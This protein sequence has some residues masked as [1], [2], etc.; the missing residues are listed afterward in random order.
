MML[1]YTEKIDLDDKY[2]DKISKVISWY[3]QKISYI[4]DNDLINISECEDFLIV[5]S[6]IL[7]MIPDNLKDKYINIGYKLAK[8]I[9][10]KIES[11]NFSSYYSIFFEGL[12]YSAYSIY[13]FNK[14]TGLLCNFLKDINLLLLN[15]SYKKASNLISSYNNDTTTFNYDVIYGLSGILNYLLDV[16]IKEEDSYKIETIIKYLVMVTEHVD[17]NDYTI[18][19][20]FIPNENLTDSEKEYFKFGNINLGLSHGIAGPLKV[21]TKARRK[22]Y[23]IDGIEEAILLLIKIYEKFEIKIGNVITWPATIDL[24]EYHS[25]IIKNK[26]NYLDLYKWCYGS[27]SLSL[28]LSS[29]YSYKNNKNMYL[30]YMNNCK[31]IS[32][33]SYNEYYFFTPNICHGYSSMLL[34]TLI[35]YRKM[36]D[37]SILINIHFILDRILDCFDEFYEYGFKINLDNETENYKIKNYG[38]L[39]GTSGIILA[40]LFIFNDNCNFVKLLFLD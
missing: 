11:N 32:L 18:P 39:D 19:K 1:L 37:K 24:E 30:K 26:D 9:K 8:I 35:A 3:L 33:K 29:V 13:L 17:Y 5:I 2:R 15:E 31:L 36:N 25:N 12:G 27:F 38:F 10:N 40:L 20:I 22:H 14:N 23:N 21:L 4:V 7:P 28:I 6:E 34:M 16:E